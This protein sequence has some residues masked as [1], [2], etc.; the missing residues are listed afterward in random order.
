MSLEFEPQ[1]NEIPGSGPGVTGCGRTN[2]GITRRWEHL[3]IQRAVRFRTDNIQTKDSYEP[4]AFLSYLLFDNDFKL[5]EDG[6]DFAQVSEAAEIPMSDPQNHEHERL[7]LQVTVRKEG[8]IY[9]YVSNLSDQN[10][11]V[12]FD[13]L[14]IKHKYSSIVA[15]GDYYP[16]GLSIKDRTIHRD[17]YRFGYQGQFAE[18]DEETGWNHF[19]LRE[20]DAVIGRT[21]TVDPARQFHSPYMWVGN[22][23]I[24][25][26]D[27]TG[28]LSPIYSMDGEFLGTDNQGL[29]GP[30]IYMDESHFVQG[31]S[32]ESALEVGF[33]SRQFRFF[34]FGRDID[35]MVFAHS[36][37]LIRRPDWDGFVTIDEGVA[38]ALAHP[39]A[40]QNPTADNS[41][42]IN[43]ALLDF[44]D[45]STSSFDALN[46]TTPVNLFSA[47]NT[48][49]SIT[50]P[51]LRATVYALGRVN[52]VLIHRENR[53]IR[54]VNDAA[55][56]YDWNGGGGMVRSNFIRAERARTG[57]ND[58][59]GF[60]AYYYGIGTLRK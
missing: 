13:D 5:Q 8:F 40:L 10:M 38:W 3:E 59:H 14:R 48:Y 29:K 49:N 44:G 52:M 41:L 16:F 39:G 23:P 24:S 34:E 51:T 7:S 55:T 2:F 30:V 33:T 58:S 12:Y 47:T 60:K 28:G 21:L 32:H 50:N 9:I 27:P 46:K 11:D 56:D 18:R 4:Q 31:M 45:V 19:E 53:Q 22:N 15:G 17:P 20:Y 25:G 43:S 6:F 54:I 57:L 42:Y 37:S 1:S 35:D 26:T 36:L